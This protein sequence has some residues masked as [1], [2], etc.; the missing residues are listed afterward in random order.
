MRNAYFTV[1]MEHDCPPYLSGWRGIDEGAPVLL[2]LLARHAVPSTMFLT[3]AVMRRDEGRVRQWASAGHELACHGDAHIRYSKLAPAAA[4]DNLARATETLS[5]LAEVRC[6]RAPNLDLPSALL[7]RIRALG[8]RVDSSEGRH[9]H[10][11]ARLRWQAG[12]L[13]VPTS[14]TSS[15][16]RLPPWLVAPILRRLPAPLVLFVHP[17]ELVDWRTTRLRYDCR[18]RTGPPAVAAL[19]GLFRALKSSGF[20][21]RPLGALL[22]DAAQAP[23]DQAIC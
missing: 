15:L 16:L 9:K 19:D 13:R 4:I 8:Y 6:F 17:W 23:S 21:F 2:D 1:D 7:P 22:D 11:R 5:R 20:R 14:A 3:G 18:M 12:V 10:A